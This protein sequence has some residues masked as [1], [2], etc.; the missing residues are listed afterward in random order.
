LYLSKIDTL[1]KKWAFEDIT[2]TAG[3]KTSRWCTGVSMVDVNQDG[4]LDIYISVARHPKMS[5]PADP[6]ASENLLF[7]NQGLAANK[8]P[9]FKEMAKAYGLN[10]ASFTVQTAFFDADLDGDLDVYMM[11]SAPDL[12][13]PNYLRQTYNDGS[14]PSTGKL[15]RNE[16]VGENGIPVFTNISKEAGVRYEGLGLGTRCK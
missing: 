12:Q 7:V 16:G 15:Y 14:Y 8:L 3:V 6:E 10:D 4:L 1:S 11:N 2:E 5:S 9:K 13:N